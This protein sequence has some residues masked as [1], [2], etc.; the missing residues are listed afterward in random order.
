M[1]IPR[2]LTI[3]DYIR[4]MIKATLNWTNKL[5]R[6]THLDKLLGHACKSPFFPP[7]ITTNV[8]VILQNQGSSLILQYLLMDVTLPA[9]I[10]QSLLNF[11]PPSITPPM[12]SPFSVAAVHATGT[13]LGVAFAWSLFLHPYIQP[14]LK[15]SRLL[16]WNLVF[17]INVFG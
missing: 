9:E 8:R 10:Q 1:L 14:V 12:L 7:C 3:Y 2:G 16:L 15:S 5:A 17:S 4:F 6:P 11:L 13:R